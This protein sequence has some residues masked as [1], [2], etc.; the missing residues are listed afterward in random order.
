MAATPSGLG[1]KTLSSLPFCLCSK[2]ND[3]S[4]NEA[5]MSSQKNHGH[6]QD[7]IK[8]KKR[9][10][11]TRR[12]KKRERA[13]L[14]TDV[15]MEIL[16][17][18]PGKSLLRCKC[19][20]KSWYHLISNSSFT[21]KHLIQ[22]TCNPKVLDPLLFVGLDD[23]QLFSFISLDDDNKRIGYGDS[24]SVVDVASFIHPGNF[25]PELLL[26]YRDHCHG[27]ICLSDHVTEEGLVALWNP[28]TREFR[29][30]PKSPLTLSSS[31]GP[32]DWTGF[33]YDAMTSDFKVVRCRKSKTFHGYKEP[34]PPVELYRLST[35]S[36]TLL[37]VDAELVSLYNNDRCCM[38]AGCLWWP[39]KVEDMWCPITDEV[40]IL[41]WS[42]ALLRFDLNSETFHKIMPPED[43]QGIRD[44]TPLFILALE[45][46]V[47]LVL[48]EVESSKISRCFDIWVMEESGVDVSW[49]KI[50]SIGPIPG[51][52]P[53]S[54][55]TF[56]PI[57]FWGNNRFLL[58][59]HGEGVIIYELS[60]QKVKLVKLNVESEFCRHQIFVYKDSFLKIGN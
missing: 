29:I 30:L 38:V 9:S 3:Q 49:N 44:I 58:L 50:L 33:G 24:M 39:L 17:R 11:F 32:V 23:R 14:P 43:L 36:W 53:R 60:T 59:R 2:S 37:N 57:A 26:F 10:A 48:Y 22:Y 31:H 56:E 13:A 42:F 45:K 40:G 1:V 20:C 54:V 25:C 51:Y 55:G 19:V 5:A 12:G 52:E 16:S 4:E 7:L 6:C 35:N 46:R 28:T 27:I 41:R 34:E 15:W 18:L 8:K 21:L 47:A